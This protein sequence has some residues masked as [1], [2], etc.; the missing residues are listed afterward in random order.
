MRERSQ[1]KRSKSEEER[2]TTSGSTPESL[3]VLSD[4]WSTK[5]PDVD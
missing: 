4:H 3:R 5:S 1:G 2:L